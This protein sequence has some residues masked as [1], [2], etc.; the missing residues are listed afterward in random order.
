MGFVLYQTDT[1]GVCRW[2]L[3]RFEAYYEFQQRYQHLVV[4]SE[5]KFNSGVKTRQEKNALNFLL[6]FKLDN[7][8]IIIWI[9]L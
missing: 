5:H 3:C 2:N 7:I 9:N 4:E 8:Y 6:S 1:A